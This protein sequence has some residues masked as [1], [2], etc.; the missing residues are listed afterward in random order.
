MPAKRRTERAEPLAG[1]LRA[2]GNP[3]TPGLPGPS[4]GDIAL[5]LSRLPEWHAHEGEYVLVYDGEAHGFY[6]TRDEAMA[7]GYRRFGRV[8]FLVKRVDL[9]E[10]PRPLVG[11]AL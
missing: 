7:E 11:V 6:P 1:V 2:E 10:R 4:Q 8:P 5:Y 9:G 3:A